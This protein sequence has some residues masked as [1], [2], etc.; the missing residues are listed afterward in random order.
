METIELEK[1]IIEIIQEVCDHQEVE[2]VV[3]GDFYPGNFIMS[4]V[5]VS[6]FT[7]I[8]IKTGITIPNNCYIFHDSKTKRQLN[9]KE[10]AT[11]L[12]ALSKN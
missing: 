3:N 12:L 4:Q 11:K 10:A 5:L 2:E 7:Q 9:I 8:E 1:E 6:I